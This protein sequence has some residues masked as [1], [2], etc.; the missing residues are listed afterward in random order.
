MPTSKGEGREGEKGRKGVGRE[1]GRGKREGE[2]GGKGMGREEGK[3]R[4][5]EGGKEKD[6]LH[7]TLFLGPDSWNSNFD[8]ILKCNYFFLNPKPTIMQWFEKNFTVRLTANKATSDYKLGECTNYRRNM[9]CNIITR[10]DKE[11]TDN[12]SDLLVWCSNG[13]PR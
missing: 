12:G 10:A 5:G 6:D 3:G 11:M 7:P 2:K 13:E 8:F 9:L 4:G 1:K